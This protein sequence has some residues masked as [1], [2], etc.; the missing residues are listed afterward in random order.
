MYKLNNR[1]MKKDSI[2]SFPEKGNFGNSNN[3]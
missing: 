3:C 2:L 1:G